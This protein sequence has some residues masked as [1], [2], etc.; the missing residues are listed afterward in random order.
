MLKPR[1]LKT[2]L[3]INYKEI[4]ATN[5]RQLQPQLHREKPVKISEINAQTK[6]NCRNIKENNENVVVCAAQQKENGNK[7]IKYK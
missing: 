3:K 1:D 7:I 4:L 2:K 6:R 5:R